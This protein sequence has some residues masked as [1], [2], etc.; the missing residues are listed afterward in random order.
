MSR[1]SPLGAALL[2]ALLHGAPA[3]AQPAAE[4]PPLPVQARTDHYGALGFTVAGGVDV[5]SAIGGGQT[6]GGVRAP[7]EVGVTLGVTE[8]TE[9]RLAGRLGLPWPFP[10][11]SVTAGIRNSRGEQWKT[12]FD[13]DFAAHLSPIWT[14]GLRVGFGVQYD[15]LPV[16]GVFAVLAFQGG[17]GAGLRLAGELLLGFQLRSY[18]FF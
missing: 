15:V 17:G 11:W 12:F 10:D 13:L 9:V 14:L 5:S 16:L 4:P 1:A 2:L 18:L 3:Q 7:V 6:A 8:K